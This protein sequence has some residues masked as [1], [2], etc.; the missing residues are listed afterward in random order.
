MHR[1]LEYSVREIERLTVRDAGQ[2]F[3]GSDFRSLMGSGVYV[4]TSGDEC[5]YVGHSRTM[6]S[7]AAQSKHRKAEQASERAD[8]VR[9]YPTRTLA[10]AQRLEAILI[11]RLRPTLNSARPYLKILAREHGYSALPSYARDSMPD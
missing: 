7:R 5:L 3:S 11:E 8:L 4:F 10:D 6:L 1:H 9:F 2:Q